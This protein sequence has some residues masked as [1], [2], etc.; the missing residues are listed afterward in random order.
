MP[1]TEACERVDYMVIGVSMLRYA[2]MQTYFRILYS[3]HTKPNSVAI[4]MFL[5]SEPL[6]TATG[7][8]SDLSFFS[9]G[10]YR[11]TPNPL[12]NREDNSNYLLLYEKIL[13]TVVI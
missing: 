3:V 1:L 11:S 13:E 5:R 9:G 12:T 7:Q 10:S 4:R 6:A 8:G 2:V